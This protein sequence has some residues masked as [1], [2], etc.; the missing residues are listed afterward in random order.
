MDRLDLITLT[1]YKNPRTPILLN[2][3]GGAFGFDIHHALEVD[4]LIRAYEC[5]AIIETGT[6]LGDTTR[7]LSEMYSNLPVISIESNSIFFKGAEKKLKDRS[8]VTLLNESSEHAIKKFVD[9]FNCPFFY[10][11]AHNDKPSPKYGPKS[12]P[13]FIELE[14]IKRGIVCIGDFF[15]GDGALQR[16]N[17]L[18]EFNQFD[19]LYGRDELDGVIMDKHFVQRYSKPSTKLYVNNASNTKAYPLPCHQWKRR[20]G[21]GYFGIGVIEDWFKDSNFFTIPTYNLTY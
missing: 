9:K 20:S 21:R 4:Y 3:H 2:D 18:D 1:F 17:F 14:S 16:Y 11:D 19:I 5:D 6:F 15:I 12:F 7:Y 8:N 10:L 13:I